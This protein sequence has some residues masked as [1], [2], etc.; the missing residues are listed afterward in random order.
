[1][2]VDGGPDADRL[3]TGSGDDDVTGGSGADKI[4]TGRGKDVVDAADDE[5]DVV[6]CGKGRDRVRA[7]RIDVVEHCEVTLGARARR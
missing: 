2:T 7:D 4:F 5:R 3:R 1:M 6:D